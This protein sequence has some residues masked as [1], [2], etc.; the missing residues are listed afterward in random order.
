[1][2]KGLCIIFLTVF[3]AAF[4]PGCEQIETDKYVDLRYEV[5]D[6]YVVEARNPAVIKFF[7]ERRSWET[8]V[9]RQ[10]S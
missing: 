5:E 2:K 4:F 1:M 8:A 10:E 3:A 9:R 6:S 7:Q